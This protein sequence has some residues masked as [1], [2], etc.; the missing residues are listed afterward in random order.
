MTEHK[1]GTRE[2]WQR[3]T[4]AA[5]G[6]REGAHP[7]QRRARAR[8]AR[9]ALGADREGVQLRDRRGDQD[10]RRALRRPLAAARL[11]LHVRPRLRG[12]LPGLLV[13]RRH[14]QRRRPAPERPRRHVA[15]RLARAAREAAGVQA[16]HGLDVPLGV[17]STEATSTSTSASRRRRSRWR[18]C[19][20][21]A[22]PPIV[23]Q[24][25]AACGTDPAGYLTEAPALSA[26]ALE[27]GVVHHTYSTYARGVEIMMG[28]YPL[29]D[30]AP[31]DAT[32][33]RLRVLD[34]PPRRVLMQPGH[35]VA[36]PSGDP[37]ILAACDRGPRPEH[38][39]CGRR[40]GGGRPVLV[41]AWR[42]RALRQAKWSRRTRH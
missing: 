28:F 26:F 1:V 38:R 19:W 40:R 17:V 35:T 20:R 6:A 36:V 12:G 33:R 18:R 7:P 23:E 16:A 31:R 21:P 27:D 29:L 24:L 2:E 37:G 41:A 10:A 25:A 3:R 42:G 8:A 4:R 22:A 11:P 32:R 34:P 9:A 5:A 13:E 30:R 15:L 39:R 14:L